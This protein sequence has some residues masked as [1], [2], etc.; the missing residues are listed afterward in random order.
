[1]TRS[2]SR[3][4]LASSVAA[5]ALGAAPSAIGA[6]LVAAATDLGPTP[7]ADTVTVSLVLKIQHPEALEAFVALSQEPLLPT[8]H[9]FLSVNQ[10]ADLFA[11]SRSDIANITRFLKG[12]GITVNEVFADRLLI[13]ATGTADAFNQAF[14][15]DMHDV[16]ENG[17]RFHR[18]HHN[19]IIPV[20]F[21]DLLISV[22]GLNNEP[23]FAHR[24]HSVTAN[25]PLTAHPPVLPKSGA[26]ATGVPGS[27]TVGDTA[28]MYNINPLYAA[29]VDGTG[30]TVGIVTLAGFDPADAFTYWNLI[31]LSVAS[32]KV[33]QVHVDGGGE[34][35]AEAGTGETCLDV[36]QSGGLAP[37]AKM[38]VYDAPNS[39][40]GFI[41]LFYKAASDN[42]VD[43]M[44]CSWGLAEA[45]LFPEVVGVDNR[46]QMIAFH[47][48]FL[49]AAAQGISVFAA[50]GDS[51]AFDINDAFNDPVNNVL[52]V[53]HPANDPAITAAG[54]TTTPFTLNAGPGTPDL[55]VA[56]E[57]VWGWDFIEAYL[58]Q[59]VDPSLLH[60]LFPSGGGGG[61]STFWPV[62]FYQL[63]VKGIRKTEPN[64]SIIF[65]DGSGAGPQDLLDLPANFA[66]RNVPD[67]SLDADPFSGYLLFSSRDGG[68]LSG[69]GGTSFV[70]P[71]LNGIMA[72]VGQ[73]NG[74][75]RLG[76]INPMLYRFKRQV[77]ANAPLVDI[78]AGDNWFYN[79]IPGYEPGA[80]LGVLNVANFSA[81]V[82][83]EA[84]GR[85]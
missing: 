38:V 30:R 65:D 35:S 57:Q 40:A 11:P 60:Q 81:A 73:A 80:G 10:F 50:S 42:V 31:G 43:T 77:G 45:F 44:S 12:F 69:F 24:H 79:G 41:D 59:F 39:D 9:R 25:S 33:T 66:G 28:N 68:L 13:K 72:L 74:N 46:P 14:S 18:H 8:Y 21:R 83:R 67:V 2:L 5:V 58:V 6:P 63:G 47:Q 37:G 7:A 26:I 54:G 23:K 29:G 62:P 61:V 70:A 75:H 16:K 51:G 48:A 17:K 71:Q 55:V 3:T 64:Q 56:K 36:E 78:T 52:T 76:L 20:L 27:F 85:F 4:L 1:M 19:P 15:A 84:R 82:G 32:N 22:E 34:I 49:E 53:D